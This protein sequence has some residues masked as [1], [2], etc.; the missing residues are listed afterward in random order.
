YD[1]GGARNPYSESMYPHPLTVAARARGLGIGYP[2]APVTT[3]RTYF[4]AHKE[5]LL[6]GAEGLDAAETRVADYSDWAV[7][8]AWSPRRGAGPGTTMTATFGHGLP[9]VYLRVRGGAAIVE[10]AGQAEIWSENGGVVGLTVGGHH[11]G[12]FAPA[13]TSWTRAAAGQ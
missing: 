6:V 12:L 3:A 4:F 13:G 9:F 11:Y 2:T 5:D 7:T 1:R 8:A 10:P